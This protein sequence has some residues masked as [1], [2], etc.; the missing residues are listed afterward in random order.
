MFGGLFDTVLEVHLGLFNIQFRVRS[1]RSF[2]FVLLSFL[3]IF[4]VVYFR[5]FYIFGMVWG[6]FGKVLGSFF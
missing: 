4:Q 6:S 2:V 5:H 1:F 3:L